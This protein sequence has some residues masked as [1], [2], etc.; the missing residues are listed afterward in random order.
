VDKPA[1][2]LSVPARLAGEDARPVLGRRLEEALGCR[3]W[4]VHRLDAEVTGIIL[5]AK[6]AE[7]HREAGRWFEAREVDKAYEALTEGTVPVSSAASGAPEIWRSQLLRGKKRAYESPHGKAA[8]TAA[9]P[10]GMVE[11]EGGP[12][13]QWALTPRTGRPHQLRFELAKH[14]FPILGDALYGASRPWPKGG[15]ALRCV[16][17]GFAACRGAAALG[18]PDTLAV[19]G[20]A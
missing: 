8:E 13:L 16:R 5:Y 14:G 4:P 12:A 7:A 11:A 19:A 17:L 6:D 2:W 3:L 18:L 9:R 1:G 15:I 10:L 20:L